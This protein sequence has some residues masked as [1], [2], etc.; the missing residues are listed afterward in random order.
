MILKYK[1][2]YTGAQLDETIAAYLNKPEDYSIGDG[3]N[4][5][6]SEL[7]VDSSVLRT[8]GDQEITGNISINGNLKV[9]EFE[10]NIIKSPQ[11][12]DPQV[13]P[14][15]IDIID[16]VA[17]DFDKKVVV[18]NLTSYGHIFGDPLT[19]IN[20]DGWV[21]VNGG[22]RVGTHS[23]VTNND[24]RLSDSRTP[25]SHTHPIDQVT[26]LQTSLDGKASKV[27]TITAV[28]HGAN[29]ST[30]RPAGFLV[31]IWY[32]TVEPTNASNNDIWI[33]TT[34]V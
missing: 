19:G 10:V 15:P 11:S 18:R 8:D 24:S 12:D 2:A 17:I 20:V 22:I 9:N 1:S 34:V 29:A 26:N 25:T 21:D 14:S 13:L 5:V 27:E 33:D 32:G 23:V 7:S 3:L 30:A 28:F 6:E 16:D 4:I 31:V